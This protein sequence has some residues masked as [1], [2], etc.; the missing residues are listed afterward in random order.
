MYMRQDVLYLLQEFKVGIEWPM[1]LPGVGVALL[2]EGEEGQGEERRVTCE[3]QVDWMY[4]E[5]SQYVR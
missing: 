3:L 1:C 5:V 2:R 4:A